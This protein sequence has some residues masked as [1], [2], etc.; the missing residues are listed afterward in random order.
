ML[1][2]EEMVLA[3][4]LSAAAKKSAAAAVPPPTPPVAVAVSSSTGTP[5]T[6]RSDADYAALL[7]R[8]RAENKPLVLFVGCPVRQVPGTIIAATSSFW[9]AAPKSIVVGF[10]DGT[11][12]DHPAVATDE[13]LLRVEEVRPVQPPPFRQ[14]VVQYFTAPQQRATVNC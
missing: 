3:M 6:I 7:Q 5:P 1:S 9:D 2:V 14:P 10:P 12:L 8:A 11:R 4:M 13:Q